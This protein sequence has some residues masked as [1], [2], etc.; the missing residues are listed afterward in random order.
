[1]IDAA[2]EAALRAKNCNMAPEMVAMSMLMEIMGT[3]SVAT[4]KCSYGVV[5]AI[6]EG[7]LAGA[8]IEGDREE[9]DCPI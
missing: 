9:L 1:M 5:T 4:F 2:V 8:A 6:Y 3:V 7:T